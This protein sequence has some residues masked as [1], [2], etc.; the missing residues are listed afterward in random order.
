[1]RILEI[2][3]FVRNDAFGFGIPVEKF[4]FKGGRTVMSE[5]RERTE[6]TIRE[7]TVEETLAV[8]GALN[9]PAPKP[10]PFGNPLDP[11]PGIPC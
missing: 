2:L 6:E 3:R 7:L 4:T 8:S 11:N 10:D 9:I 5:T 1:M